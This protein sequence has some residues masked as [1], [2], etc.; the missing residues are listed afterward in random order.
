MRQTDTKL[1]AAAFGLLRSVAS[2]AQAT[3]QE[4]DA[5]SEAA[6]RMRSVRSAMTKQEKLLYEE[7]W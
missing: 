1:Q 4:Q 5:D 7:N 3:L 6:R 2:L